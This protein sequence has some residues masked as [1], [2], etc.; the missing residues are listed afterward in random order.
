MVR[1]AKIPLLVLSLLVAVAIVAGCT[2]TP[3]IQTPPA[4]VTT[5][6]PTPPSENL[7]RAPSENVTPTLPPS[8]TQRVP[9]APTPTPTPAPTPVT[10]D[11]SYTKYSRSN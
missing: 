11:R 2:R 6:V 7:T 8:E 4:L 5:P 1:H 10:P 9:P 3:A